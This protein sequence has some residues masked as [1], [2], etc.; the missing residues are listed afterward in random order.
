M[1]LVKRKGRFWR[2][3]GI[4]YNWPE[5]SMK[6]DINLGARIGDALSHEMVA[7]LRAAAAEAAGRAWRLYLVGGTVRDLL[8]GRPGFDV[9]L[10]VEGDAIELAKIIAASPD[11]V[12]VHHRFNT[13]KLTWGAHQIDIARCREETYARPGALPT[14]RP[15]SIERDLFRRDFTINAMAVSLNPDDWARLIDLYQGGDDLHKGF[16]RIL[17]SNSFIDDATRMWRAVRYEQR[18][19][20]CIEPGTLELL[21][22]DIGLLRTI[23]PDRLRYELECILGEMVPEKVFRR[24][25]ELGLL[26]TW[27]PSLRGDD[28]L[29]EACLRA[30]LSIEKV[31][32]E[33]YL[34][35]LG[36]RLI[37][38]EKEEL[39]AILRLTKSQSRVLRDSQ[40]IADNLEIL[41][42]AVTKPSGVM[43]ILQG[44][45]EDALTAGKAAVD[46]PVAT[47]NISRYMEE[48]RYVIPEL[49]G[50]DLSALGV[51][52]GPDIK[53]LIEQIKKLRLDGLLISREQ[54]GDLVKEWLKSR[55]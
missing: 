47:L 13:A 48:W 31:S 46:S 53:T 2:P 55:S 45:G 6:H 22:R 7:F 5:K 38:V 18:L 36:W 52:R 23:S 17:H 51:G 16:I 37:E 49:T 9:D 30:R 54:E 42:S 27:H 19:N 8:L 41:G 34:A 4:V 35:L 33:V 3:C 25:D 10:S 14:V 1:H 39:I 50:D 28:W 24:A 26:A 15:G 21:K 11:E 20:F 44:V 43:A 32:P 40:R 29:S 12:T